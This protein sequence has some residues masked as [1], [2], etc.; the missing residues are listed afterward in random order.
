MEL[1][2]VDLVEPIAKDFKYNIDFW[3]I[4]RY[5]YSL[6]GN[7]KRDFIKKLSD[8]ENRLYK[9]I[10]LNETSIKNINDYF[11]IRTDRIK[12]RFDLLRTEEEAKETC[13]TL[14]LTWEET[15]SKKNTNSYGMMV[16]TVSRISQSVCEKFKETIDINPQTRCIW[17]KNG[18]LHVTT[19][20]LDGAIPSLNNPYVV[21]EIKEYWGKSKGGSKMS[22][23]VYECEIVGKELR[24]YERETNTKIYH[25]VFID[26]K[27]QW[28]YRKSDFARFIDLE[29]R[30]LIDYLIIGHPEI[31]ILLPL[32]F[33]GILVLLKTDTSII[34]QD[35]ILDKN[36][37]TLCM[38]LCT[39]K[40]EK[41]LLPTPLF[42]KNLY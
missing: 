10:S 41:F 2:S 37:H 17:S 18:K 32:T 27:D 14:G 42:T 20:N 12:T 4:I 33:K 13:K 5:F 19:R 38:I 39:F 31:T 6:R 26:G 7:E 16:K 29:A 15:K 1:E 3:Q 11:D 23:A 25:V 34:A 30:G 35:L 22:D 8:K 21:W 24:E 36:N 28:N 40:W 9:L